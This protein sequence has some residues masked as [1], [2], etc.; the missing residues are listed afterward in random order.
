MQKTITENKPSQPKR[1]SYRQIKGNTKKP[2][3]IVR[4]SGP[5][6]PPS[7]KGSSRS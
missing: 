6:K 1:E 4:S 2:V 7:P 3:P 5:K